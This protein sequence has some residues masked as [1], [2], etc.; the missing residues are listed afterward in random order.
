MDKYSLYSRAVQQPDADALF[1]RELCR[2][3]KGKTPKVLREDFCGTFSLCR[4]WVKLGPGYRAYGRDIDPEP[5]LYGRE[6]GLPKLTA[7]QR[8][9]VSI[10]TKDVLEPGGA[11]A[12][13][14]LA[15]NFS[16]FTLKTRAA[17][18]KYLINSRE[19]LRRGGVLALDCF[20]GEGVQKAGV[21]RTEH[22]G[23]V[24]YWEQFGFDRVS[25]AAR[26]AIHFKPEGRR[27]VKN[28]FSYDWRIWTIPEIRD[29]LSE[30]GFRKT[31]VYWE[32]NDSKR[33]NWGFTRAGKLKMEK[34]WIAFIA[35]EK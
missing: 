4:E 33:G 32:G 20:G 11:A 10:E 29:L 9:R 24:Y 3:L 7:A 2:E 16:Y 14:I 31:H 13:L 27:M 12:D 22:R 8:S 18:K 30:A 21:E 28:V 1:F 5:I 26:F 23:F 17:F 6:R 35:A 19:R 15:V 34:V 25:A